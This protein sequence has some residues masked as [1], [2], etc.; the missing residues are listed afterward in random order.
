MADL[1][2]FRLLRIAGA[3]RDSRFAGAVIRAFGWLASAK[4]LARVTF[5]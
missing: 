2:V 5:K 3:P 4:F 1:T